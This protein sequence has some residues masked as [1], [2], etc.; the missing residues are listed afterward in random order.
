MKQTESQ[1]PP[2]EEGS[3]LMRGAEYLW[4]D[5]VEGPLMCAGIGCT[6]QATHTWGGWPTCDDCALPMRATMN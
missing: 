3:H 5:D 2:Q 4:Q 6:N 1:L